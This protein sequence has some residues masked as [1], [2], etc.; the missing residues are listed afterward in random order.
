MKKPVDEDAQTS[1]LNVLKDDARL[2]S[3]E[4]R[5]VIVD[6]QFWKTNFVMSPT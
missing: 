1:H 5:A 4:A 2:D 6:R 3:N